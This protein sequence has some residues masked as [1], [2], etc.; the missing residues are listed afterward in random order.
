MTW[1]WKWK[2]MLISISSKYSY[3][4]LILNYIKKKLSKGTLIHQNLATLVC[5]HLAITNV[6]TVNLVEWVEQNQFQDCGT[7]ITLHKIMFK[8]LA[9]LSNFLLL[10]SKNFHKELWVS[11]SKCCTSS[12]SSIAYI[13][14]FMHLHLISFHDNIMCNFNVFKILWLVSSAQ[15]ENDIFLHQDLFFMVLVSQVCPMNCRASLKKLHKWCQ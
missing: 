9:L 6:A 1:N 4:K 8:I 15:V 13:F 2:K 14:A 12:Q 3:C 7:T 11:S 5:F 10:H